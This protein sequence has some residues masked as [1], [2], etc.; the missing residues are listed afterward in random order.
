M[1]SHKDFV[2]YVAEQLREA[3]IKIGFHTFKI[4]F[5]W[6]FPFIMKPCGC[7]FF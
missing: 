4:S 7:F 1:A 3:G 5:L 2:D 6:H